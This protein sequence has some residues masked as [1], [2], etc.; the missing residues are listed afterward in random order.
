MAAKKPPSLED[1]IAS[2]TPAERV[3]SVCVAGALIAEHQQLEHE[4]D[5]AQRADTRTRLGQASA[6]PK[7][8]QQIEQ[9]QERMRAQTYA[10]RFR[11]VESKVWS[12][13][14]AA[15][16]DP[17]GKKIFNVETFPPA[18]IS[19]CCVEPDGMHDPERVA[20]LLKVLNPAQ[21]DELF[22]GAWDVNTTAPKEMT[23]YAASAVLR[24]S[25]TSSA[26]ASPSDS[27]VPSSSG[28]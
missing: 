12:D 14:V 5:R 7:I 18:A 16:P 26:T 20:G 25:E 13:L 2:A 3:V 8:A 11:A 27:P 22:N 28:E 4:L 24:C 23:S 19:A 6:A 17:A 21:Q 9:L 10:F 1:I 15:H